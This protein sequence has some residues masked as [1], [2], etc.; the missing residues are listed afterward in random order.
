MRHPQMEIW[1]PPY[2]TVADAS[3][4]ADRVARRVEA[5]PDVSKA[6]IH[7]ELAS[8]QSIHGLEVVQRDHATNEDEDED[9]GNG[10]GE[11]KVPAMQKEVVKE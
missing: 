1:L 11:G 9:D 3:K 5:L 10:E 6:D 7:L 2:M 8:P 4:I